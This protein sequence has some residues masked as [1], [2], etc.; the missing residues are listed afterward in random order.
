MVMY[1]ITV[2][3]LA[4]PGPE[5]PFSIERRSGAFTEKFGDQPAAVF[6]IRFLTDSQDMTLFFKDVKGRY[7]LPFWRDME[8]GD[9]VLLANLA[10]SEFAGVWPEPWLYSASLDRATQ[11]HDEGLAVYGITG[12]GNELPDVSGGGEFKAEWLP[13]EQFEE[14][15]NGLF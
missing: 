4:V 6:A 11:Y 8:L 14:Q 15:I 5:D 7:F 12:Y 2:S 10:L 13:S 3:E 9:K 1:V